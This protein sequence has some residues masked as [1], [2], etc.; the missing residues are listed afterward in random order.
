YIAMCDN[1]KET[2][3]KEEKGFAQDHFHVL[4]SMVQNGLTANVDAIETYAETRD[5]TFSLI[6]VDTQAAWSPVQE[7]SNNTEQRNYAHA[8][9]HLGDLPGKPAVLVLS[10]PTKSPNSASDC[11]PRGGV[12]FE[13]ET[14]GN[15]TMWRTGDLIEVGFT[16]LR[17]PPWQPFSIRIEKIET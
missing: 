17:V 10:H 5:L 14:D 6:V 4:T 13:N 2:D 7:E 12:A 8:L 9:R 16:R 1:W 3:A 11:R 15:W